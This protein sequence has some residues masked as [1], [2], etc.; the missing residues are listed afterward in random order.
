[1]DRNDWN[2]R[3]GGTELVWTADPNRF[4]VAE[5]EG[6]PPGRAL[7][8]ACGEGRNAVWLATRGWAV[9][10]VD[11][12]SAGLDKGRALAA[13][14]GVEVEWIEAD[15]TTWRP[16][17]PVFDLV[18]ILYLQV[19]AA[20]RRAA[21]IAA[22]SGLAPGGTL[23]WVGHDLDNLVSG[24]GGPQHPEVLHTADDLVADLHAADPGL[25]IERAGTVVRTVEKD[26]GRHE[27]IDTLV[28]AHRPT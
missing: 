16:S 27:A 17:G 15:V 5:V 18:V 26:D 22:V 28:R 10:G 7:D 23:L 11:F 20:G 14:A 1:M 24:Y 6:L 21:A 3:Y 13:A 25:V 2:A 12:S 19:P 9:C 8:L 4:L